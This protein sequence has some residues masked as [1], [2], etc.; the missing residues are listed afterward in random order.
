MWQVNQH[1]GRRFRVQSKLKYESY[2]IDSAGLYRLLNGIGWCDN[3]SEP[4]RSPRVVLAKAFIDVPPFS[5]WQGHSK[6][7]LP[8][9]CLCVSADNGF[10]DD[11]FQEAR[12]RNE[13]RFS[14]SHLGLRDHATHAAIVVGV[15]VGV[16]Y[17]HDRLAW[18]MRKIEVESFARCSRCSECVDDD[19][20]G[21][22]LHDRHIRLRETA[23]LINAVGDLKQS[24]CGVELRLTPKT[25]IYGRRRLALK[26]CPAIWIRRV[27]RRR[28]ESP[29][30]VIEVLPIAKRQP[31]L[32]SLVGGCD[33]G[34]RG[35]RLLSLCRTNNG[36]YR[37]KARGHSPPVQESQDH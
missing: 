32:D 30:C 36:H 8:A 5:N 27:G 3:R 21:H 35:L 4:A 13:L 17:S 25:W 12:W 22:T 19:E 20:T 33:I 26:K 1:L 9:P 11:G 18:T 31:R 29:H 14:G 24:V 2:S 34:F 16:D 10:S 7:I 6:L 28:D 15:T 23:N 37:D